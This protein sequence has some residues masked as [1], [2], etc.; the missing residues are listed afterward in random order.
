MDNTPSLQDFALIRS[1]LDKVRQDY[2]IKDV[3]N[4]F[5]VF[6]LGLIQNLQDDEIIDSIT[7][8]YFLKSIGNPSGHDRGIDAVY[9]E[10]EGTQATINLFNFKYSDKFENTKKNFPASEIDKILSFINSIMNKDQALKK[11]VNILLYQ[12]VEEIW[13]LFE[14]QNPKFHIHICG[15]LYKSFEKIEKER[16]ER[17]INKHS[18]FTITYSLMPDLVNRITKKGKIV[19]NAKI[20]AIDKNYFNKSD[21]DIKAL[22]V[23]FDARDLIRIVL[24]NEEIRN[25]P[26]IDNYNVLKDYSI[27]EDAF[28]D[29][30]RMYFKQRSAVNR[31][32]KNTALSDD[33]SRFFYFNNGITLTCDSYEYPNH[34]RAPVIE[35]SNLQVVNGSQTI[36]AL[37]EAFQEDPDKLENVDILCRVY[38]TKKE[39]LSVKIAEYTNS[40]NPVKSRDIRSIDAIQQKLE[41][42]LLNKGYYYERKKNQYSGKLKDKRLDSEKVG[43]VLMAF[44]NKMP[45]EAKNKKS[46]IFAEKYYEEIFNDYITADKVLLPYHL[47]SKIE[48]ERINKRELMLTDHNLYEKES[49]ILYASYYILYII[50]EIAVLLDIDFEATEYETLWTLYPQAIT[51]LG[52]LVQM[53]KGQAKDLYND[54]AFFKQNKPQ[55]HFEEML[56]SG[57]FKSILEESALTMNN[58]D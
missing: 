20:K 11:E 5:Q 42:E 30:V 38:E 1:C 55:K 57:K 25:K 41:Q 18:N 6:A 53:E 52:I 19:V 49:F 48:D 10:E 16:F 12:K 15:N 51:I 34:Q 35:I 36:H 47:Y 39:E 27:L 9:I 22:I 40:Q 2:D 13:N 45:G 43:Q 21:G 56:K 26:N 8:T 46:I 17:E 24:D 23:D 28:E 3:S 4:A 44:Y 31:N 29:N 54:A 7:D 50:S 32:I 37:Y 33:A 14:S 58:T